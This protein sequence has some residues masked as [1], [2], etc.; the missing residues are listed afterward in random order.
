MAGQSYSFRGTTFWVVADGAFIPQPTED[1]VSAEA[2]VPG[3]NINVVDLG[4]RGPKR[5]SWSIMVAAADTSNIINHTQQTGTLFEA[6]DT[7]SVEVSDVT[8]ESLGNHQVTRDRVWH[9]FDA[10]FLY[11]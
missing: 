1:A 8:L 6:Q 11:P 10:V 4:G 9:T 5:V 7:G 2:H 3:S